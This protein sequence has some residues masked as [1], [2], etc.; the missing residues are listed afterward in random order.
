MTELK[1]REPSTVGTVRPSGGVKGFLIAE[2]VLYAAFLLGD[3]LALGRICL[4]LKYLSVL[5]CL[6]CAVVRSRRMG[7]WSVVPP[8]ALTCAA[9][10][11]LLPG[12]HVELGICLFMAVQALYARRINRDTIRTVTVRIFLAVL[13][14]VMLGVLDMATRRN[15]LAGLY[16][17]QLVCNAVLARRLDGRRGRLFA[18]G[19]TLFIG[20]DVCVG[21]WNLPGLPGVVEQAAG[22]GMWL[23]YLP[24]QMCIALSAGKMQAG[25]T[26]PVDYAEKT[27]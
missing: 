7:E 2:A 1:E 15:L 14:W 24:S 22:F 3:L 10:A 18:V 27:G 11:L 9:D 21:L 4:L 8:M 6:A 13:V 17:P 26:N 16:F 5:L 25:R 12:T 19:L 20:C 23:F